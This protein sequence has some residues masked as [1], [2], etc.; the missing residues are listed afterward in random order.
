MKHLEILELMTGSKTWPVTGVFGENAWPRTRPHDGTDFATST[1]TPLRVPADAEIVFEK[2]GVKQASTTS[3][4]H[5]YG[6]YTGFYIAEWDVTLYVAHTQYGK[7]V[8]NVGDKLAKGD[9]ITLAGNTGLST[10]PHT[11]IGIAPGKHKTLQ[12]A[13]DNAIDFEKYE[14]NSSNLYINLTGA[15]YAFYDKNL[16]ANKM[17]RGNH[18]GELFPDRFGGLSYT[19]TFVEGTKNVYLIETRDFGVVRIADVPGRSTVTKKPLYDL[20]GK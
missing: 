19:A 17:R 18:K 3:F 16:D 1:G 6:N 8:V 14:V 7:S 12:S 4:G 11:H 10:G 15:A 5:D 20:K 2:Y 13:R 9:L